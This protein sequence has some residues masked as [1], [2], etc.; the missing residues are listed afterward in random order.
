MTCEAIPSTVG[1]VR[2]VKPDPATDQH[3]SPCEVVDYGVD[4]TRRCKVN[5]N[6]PKIALQ[7]IRTSGGNIF[8]TFLDLKTGHKFTRD[9]TGSGPGQAMQHFIQ[10]ELSP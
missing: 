9:L 5:L 6:E 3:R 10:H 7:E 2:D 1:V 8:G 4:K